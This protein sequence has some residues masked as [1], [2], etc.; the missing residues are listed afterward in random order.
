[1]CTPMFTAALFTI[2]KIWKPLKCLSRDGWI[3]E[4]WYTY[5]YNIILFSHEKEGNAASCNN[6]DGP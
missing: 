2:V 6:M 4:L 3:N 5:A 1:M